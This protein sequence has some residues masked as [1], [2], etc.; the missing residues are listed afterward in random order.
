MIDSYTAIVILFII[1][2]PI[3]IG[4]SILS[5]SIY[6]ICDKNP[7]VYEDQGKKVV[8]IKCLC[9]CIGVIV[10]AHIFS[11]ILYIISAL[12]IYIISIKLLFWTSLI[13]A[14]LVT[15]VNITILIL[16]TYLI[17]YIINVFN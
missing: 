3:F 6:I 17:P 10:M 8:L 15:A 13:N 4:T 16:S 7:N 11:G 9:I 12:L 1:L 2:F 5:L 14:F